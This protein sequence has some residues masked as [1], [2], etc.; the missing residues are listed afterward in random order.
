LLVAG[1]LGPTLLLAGN[2]GIRAGEPAL[3]AAAYR[4]G[5]GLAMVAAA[6]GYRPGVTSPGGQQNDQPEPTPSADGEAAV[7]LPLNLRD[8]S[9]A[10]FPPLKTAVPSPTHTATPSPTPTVMVT[11]TATATAAPGVPACDRTTGDAGGFRFSRDGGATLAPNAHRLAD[12]AYTWDIDVH[13]RDPDDIL[14]LHQGRLYRSLD[15][16]CTF[17]AVRGVPAGDW[18]R[19]VRA[20]SAPDILVLTTISAAALAYTPDGGNTW[21]TEAL[22]DDV[23]ELSIDPSDP[24]R[25]TFVGRAPAIHSRGSVDERWTTLP[26]PLDTGQSIISAAYS[27]VRPQRWLVGSSTRGLYITDDGGQTWATSSEGL[28]ADVGDPPEPTRS[29]VPASI[30]FAPSDPEVAYA[31]VNQVGRGQSLRGIWRSGDGGRTWSRRVADEDLVGAVPARITG[32][33]RVFVSPADPDWTFFAFG[34]AYDGYGTDLFRSRDGLRSLSVS[35]FA[36]FYEVFAMAFG[37]T[38]T[39]VV[40]VGASSDIPSR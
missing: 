23:V 30:T 29:V 2:P 14:E 39:S 8:V 37:P 4:D 1:A 18:D 26:V 20:P 22:S 9:A 3:T 15:A 38:G 36:D 31:V 11:V 40:F 10:D 12:I 35:H 7:F 33:T 27:P 32:G 17:T 25:W 19:L 6:V 13:P 24:W 5:T 16:G 21:L 34:M 28:F